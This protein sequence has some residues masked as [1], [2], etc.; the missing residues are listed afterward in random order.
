MRKGSVTEYLGMEMYPVIEEPLGQELNFDDLTVTSVDSMIDDKFE[1]AR[2][3]FPESI[4]CL[5]LVERFIGMRTVT[6]YEFNN[7][8]IIGAGEE[9]G[10]DLEWN[11]NHVL[12]LG[13][14]LDPIQA[15]EIYCWNN[16]ECKFVFS[17]PVLISDF[18]EI[19]DLWYQIDSKLKAG[20]E[21]DE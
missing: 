12:D 9:G 10:I 15:S 2:Q 18:E 16:Q 17:I 6:D 7:L 4:K 1:T 13:I 5:E 8:E 21:S 11:H 20:A 19:S 14:S 3:E